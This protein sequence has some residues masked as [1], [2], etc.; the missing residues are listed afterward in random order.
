MY[1]VSLAL[2]FYAEWPRSL[3]D[4]ATWRGALRLPAQIALLNAFSHLWMFRLN[5]AA[6]SLS[7]EALFYLLFPRVFA[8]VSRGRPVRIIVWCAL[9]AL[10]APL[11][12]TALDPDRLGRPL[13]PG[14]E[15]L[16]SW[17]LKCF[18]LQRLPMFVAGVAAGRL[19]ALATLPRFAP[20]LALVVIVAVIF[21]NVVPYAFL[22]G[23]A[24]LPVFV[25][26]ALAAAGRAQS[27][28]SGG[29]W[30]ASAPVVALG[31]ASYATY[32]LHVPLFIALTRFDRLLWTR[33]A[34]LPLYGAVLLVLS[35]A[36]HRFIEEPARRAITRF[37]C[38]RPAPL[39]SRSPAST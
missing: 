34:H 14:T 2:G 4:L 31:R 29:G 27:H 8:G 11:V 17:Y 3:H 35:L 26:L 5:W 12:Y 18:P 21:T 1:I 39:P 30:P 9:A 16:W 33:L 22:Q 6:W 25:V 37:R 38:C 32:I 13:A 36:A 24:L 20:V 23:G 15:V 10:V 19:A 7:V 28:G